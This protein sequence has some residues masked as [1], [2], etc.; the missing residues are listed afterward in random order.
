VNH[1][2][3]LVVRNLDEEL[4]AKAEIAGGRGMVSRLRQS[5]AKILREGVEPRT[6]PPVIQGVGGTGFAR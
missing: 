3:Q 6:S 1:G 5:T 4:V 2:A